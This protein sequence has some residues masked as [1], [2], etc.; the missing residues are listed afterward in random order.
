[1]TKIAI[2]GTGRMGTALAQAFLGGGHEVSVW[3]RTPARAA[4]L[5]ARGAQHAGSVR[6]AVAAA[7]LV[8]GILNDYTT[9]AALLR[10]PGVAAALRG[11]TLVQL[12]SGSPSEARASAS[13]ASEHGVSYLDGAILATPDLIGKPECTILY[14]G[15]RATFTAHEPTLRAL[16][17]ASAYVS[18]DYGHAAALDSALLMYMWGV[19]FGALHGVAISQAEGIALEDYLAYAKGLLPVT[20]AFTIELIER[21]IKRDFEHTEATLDIHHGALQHALEICKARG[22]DQTVP[23]AFDRM[24]QRGRERGLGGSDFSALLTVLTVLR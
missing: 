16:A 10:E 21:S 7:E 15:E 14:A 22:L 1:M 11:K 24:L 13:W 23:L 18:A 8:I 2:L 17:G 3:N 20:D 19:L 4:T 5:V 6:D 12:A 9:S